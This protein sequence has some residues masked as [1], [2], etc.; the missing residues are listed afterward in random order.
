MAQRATPLI[1]E[2]FSQCSRVFEG[3][4]L[5]GGAETRK[6]L[7]Q[8]IPMLERLTAADVGLFDPTFGSQYEC[9]ISQRV[10]SG[11]SFSLDIFILPKSYSMPLHD[12]PR[13]TVATKMLYGSAHMEI[14]RAHV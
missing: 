6:A 11:P 13:M 3:E 7:S 4:A 2:L 5:L 1:A 12:H 14:G 10:Y 8:V 9:A